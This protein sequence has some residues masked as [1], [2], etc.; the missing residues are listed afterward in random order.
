MHFDGTH[1]KSCHNGRVIQNTPSWLHD[2][3]ID[4]MWHALNQYDANTFHCFCMTV[5]IVE[6]YHHRFPT[7]LIEPYFHHLGFTMPNRFE[8]ESYQD[9]FQIPEFRDCCEIF[10]RAGWNPFLHQL[11]G[12]D[13]EI[14]LL[15][16]MGFDG[17]EARVGHL[18]FLVTEESI[19]HG[20]K[21]PWE[22]ER[23]HKHWFVPRASHNFALKPECCHVSGSKGYHHSWIKP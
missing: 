9:L 14:S 15:F 12:F 21:L 20:T 17:R 1:F 3:L 16:T 22:G 11:Q 10:F 23:W 13:E 2:H 5:T 4:W 8:L 18:V 19:S 7:F 6:A